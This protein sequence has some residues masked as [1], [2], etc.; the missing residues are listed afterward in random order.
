MQQQITLC[1]FLF[2]HVHLPQER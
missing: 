1:C 2:S